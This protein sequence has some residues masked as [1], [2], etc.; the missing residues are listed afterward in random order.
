MYFNYNENIIK[1]MKNFH[2][3]TFNFIQKIIEFYFLYSIINY[4]I[5]ITF[6]K[7][8]LFQTNLFNL[9]TLFEIHIEL[10]LTITIYNYQ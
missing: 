2:P 10:V 4:I 6:I 9:F 5:Y 8:Y 1:L 3:I 7:N